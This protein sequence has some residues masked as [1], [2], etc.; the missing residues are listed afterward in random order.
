METINKTSSL[1]TY[2]DNWCMILLAALF[3]VKHLAGILHMFAVFIFFL[4]NI[5]SYSLRI[6]HTKTNLI[7]FDND[8]EHAESDIKKATLSNTQ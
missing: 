8:W 4:E 6:F 5:Y 7:F 1:K 2:P 3:E